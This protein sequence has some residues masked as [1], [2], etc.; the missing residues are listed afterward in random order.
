MQSLEESSINIHV[1]GDQSATTEAKNDQTDPENLPP[2][3]EISIGISDE[4]NEEVEEPIKERLEVIEQN[5]DQF[6]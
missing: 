3:F 4:E 5:T 2:A 1:E 6:E